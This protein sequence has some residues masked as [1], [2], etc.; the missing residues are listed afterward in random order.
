MIMEAYYEQANRLAKF[1]ATKHFA[2][3]EK[4]V[5][6]RHMGATITDTVLQSGLNYKQVVYPRVKNLLFKYANYRTTS[7]FII[8]I[9]TIPTEQIIGVKNKRKLS[10]VQEIS[11]L[12]YENN[13]ETESGLI[14]WLST[15]ENENR[16]ISLNG[17]GP[18]SLD[19]MKKLIGFSAIAI[20]RHLFHFLKLAGIE[21]RTYQDAS[22][23][24]KLTAEILRIGECELD[25]QIWKYMSSTADP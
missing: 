13:V 8:L 18:K 20:D 19:Y 17:F 23:L 5:P 4:H 7:D 6:Y 21:T 3:E 11:W 22:R 2:P 16:L 1:I 15:R 24:Y 12:L 10:L 14:S 9:Q 25:K